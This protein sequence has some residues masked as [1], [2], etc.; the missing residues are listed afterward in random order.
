[1]CSAI[2]ASR[3]FAAVVGPLA[4]EYTV[5]G[6]SDWGVSMEHFLSASEE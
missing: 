2:V 5:Y 3:S 6:A 4:Y 1:M